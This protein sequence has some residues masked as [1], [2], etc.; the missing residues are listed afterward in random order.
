MARRKVEVRREEILDATVEQ[1][2]RLGLAATRVADVAAAMGVSTALVFYHF[3]TK[4]DLLV[5]AFEHAVSR[6][7]ARL[8]AA[9]AQGGTTIDRLRAVVRLYGPTGTAAGWKLWI[10]AW[11]YAQREPAIRTALRRLDRR[12]GAVLLGVVRAGVE[13]GTFRTADAEASVARISALLDG[14]SVAALV[15]GSVSRKQLKAW[16]ADALAKE[17]DVDV[18]AV[19]G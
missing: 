17:L 7:L 8:D 5:A 14:L 6:D 3:G 16:I 4:D 13:D 9:V 18:A 19:T 11:A 15:Y 10:D 1:V 12:W 2:E